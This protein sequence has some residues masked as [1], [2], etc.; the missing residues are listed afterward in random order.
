MVNRWEKCA[1]YQGGGGDVESPH[2]LADSFRANKNECR[3]SRR[4]DGECGGDEEAGTRGLKEVGDGEERVREGSNIRGRPERNREGKASEV[5]VSAGSSGEDRPIGKGEGH[6][7]KVGRAH[8]V[9]KRGEDRLTKEDMGSAGVGEDGGRG[10]RTQ[11]GSMV[12]VVIVGIV[13]FQRGEGVGVRE[14]RDW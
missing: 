1:G 2:I 14:T 7:W 12:T 13:R 11:Q 8:E 10:D 5:K 3:V 6:G 4:K 9:C